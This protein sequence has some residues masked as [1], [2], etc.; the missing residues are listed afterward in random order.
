MVLR[1]IACGSGTVDKPI[2]YELIRGAMVESYEEHDDDEFE[3]EYEE[4]EYPGEFYLGEEDVI[5]DYG[6]LELQILEIAADVEAGE[7]VAADELYQ[8][9]LSEYALDEV[10]DECLN[11]HEMG[12]IRG[13]PVAYPEG[14]ESFIIEGI[15]S[16]GNDRL[17]E[18]S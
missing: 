6:E 7:Q 16:R 17:A 11:L 8:D 10:V 4:E 18:I 3:D 14:E 2:N 1:S 9:E 5:E 12:Y 15:T 13:G